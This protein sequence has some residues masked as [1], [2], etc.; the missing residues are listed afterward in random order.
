MR[1]VSAKNKTNAVIFIV[2]FLRGNP[3]P[4]GFELD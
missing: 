4:S 3:L 1:V 2:G